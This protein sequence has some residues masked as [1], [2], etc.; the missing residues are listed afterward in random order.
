MNHVL[1]IDESKCKRGQFGYEVSPTTDTPHIQFFIHFKNAKTMKAAKSFLFGSNRAY[2]AKC[3][4]TDFENWKYTEKDA[5]VLHQ[6]GEAPQEAGELSDWEKIVQMLKD[7]RSNLEIIE[8]FPGQALRIQTG[9]DK[10]RLEMQRQVGQEWRDVE[11]TYVTGQTGAGKTRHVMEKYGYENVHRVINHK[12]PFDTYRGQDVIIFE[13]FRSQQKIEDMLNWLDGYPVELK[14]RYADKFALFTKVYIISNWEFEEQYEN[15]AHNYPT[16][17]AAWVR[18][19]P[20]R[21]TITIDAG[22]DKQL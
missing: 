2:M 7:G 19:V 1:E 16:T 17:Y 15:I 9:L 21:L 3:N 12:W 20:N 18:R 5:H 13:E 10:Y 22:P 6:F 11:V 8:R 4:G 14:A